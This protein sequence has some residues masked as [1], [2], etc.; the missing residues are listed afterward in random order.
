MSNLFNRI[1]K[2]SIYLLVFLLPL[3]FL[4][5]SVEFFEFNKQYLLYF[6]VS[7]AFFSWLAKMVLIDKEIR[8]RRSP[9]D[10]PVLAF[11]AVAV[12]S[13]IFS[14]DKN[15]SLFGFY[16]RFS[17]GLLTLISFGILYFLLTNNNK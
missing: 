9:L 6:L 10:I 15:S 16:G 1:I 11:L 17:D 12:L 8:F 2:A 14:I 7:L 13:A 3:F 5:F 4:P